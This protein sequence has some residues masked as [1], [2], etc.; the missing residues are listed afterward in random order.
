[1][2]VAALVI[3]AVGLA[4]WYFEFT[5]DGGSTSAD[6]ELGII[7]L[8][9]EL[10]PTG[11]APAAQEGRPA[12]NFLAGKLD[13]GRETLTD[14]RGSYVVLN[15][16]ASWCEPCRTETPRLQDFYEGHRDAGWA[17]IG[18]NQQETESDVAGF[19]DDFGVTYP[20]LMDVTG[21]VSQGFRVGVGL[22][23]TFLIG[24]DGVIRDIHTGAIE[25]GD[26]EA[27]AAEAEEALEGAG[28]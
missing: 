28:G 27:W 9:E 15:F 2:G 21:E 19:A 17:V 4:I 8:P 22:P 10:N 25:T 6:S 5:G 1:M 12:P 16:W 7:E 11:E 26:L 20:M 23:V 13:G 24:P 18:M 14:Y 3:L